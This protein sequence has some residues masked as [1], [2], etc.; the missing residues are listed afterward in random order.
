MTT[1]LRRFDL[2]WLRVFAVL[3]LVPFHSVLIFSF[4]PEHVV[5][6]KDRVQSLPLLAFDGILYIWHMPLLFVI[7]GAA[8]WFALGRRTAGEYLW[9]RILRLLIPLVF[10]LL[11]LVP[12]MTYIHYIGRQT[13]P[14]LPEHFATFFTLQLNDLGGVRGHFTPAHL[15]FILFL[16]V[17]SLLALPLFLW[18]RREKSSHVR[19]VIARLLQNPIVLLLMLF[20]L[21][22]LASLPALA[23][24]NPFYFLALFI[25]GYLLMMEEAISRQIAR[26]MPMLM[27]LAIITTIIYMAP[28]S[29][30]VPNPRPGTA[31]A[32]ATQFAY[33]L[34][35]WTWVMG[36]MGLFYRLART[37]NAF[38]RY[39]NEAAYP[40]YILHLP[41]NTLVGYFIIQLNASIAVKF[42]L[43]NLFTFALTFAIYEFGIKRMTLTRFLFGMKPKT[44]RTSAVRQSPKLLPT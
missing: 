39:T 16:F 33:E 31:A 40:F 6:I 5:Y 41:V 26:L 14:T 7:A 28:L 44:S 23:D 9:E 34:S 22:W 18:L 4:N 11:T 24:K 25:L 1:G 20:P 10:A 2:D 15:W 35:R 37:E 27:T 19:N 3:L 43:I 21:T 42:V 36:L 30:F 13:A 38:L 17:F 32:F 8:T 29:G 12:L